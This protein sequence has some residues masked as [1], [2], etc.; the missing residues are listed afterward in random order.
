VHFELKIMPLVTQN[1]QSTTYLCHDFEL[2]LYANKQKFYGNITDN[3]VN[4]WDTPASLNMK[5]GK[6]FVDLCPPICL[7]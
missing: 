4:S 1:Q 7:A 2:T 3:L 6:R 5:N